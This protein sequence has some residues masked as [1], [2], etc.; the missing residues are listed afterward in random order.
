MTLTLL[1]DLDDTLLINNA[2]LFQEI[3][4]KALAEHL[5][6]HVPPEKMI[7]QLLAATRAMYKRRPRR[8]L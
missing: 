3:Y 8:A 5:K 2:E 1:I 6:P 7:S 4:L